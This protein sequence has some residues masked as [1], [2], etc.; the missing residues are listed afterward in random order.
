MTMKS[1]PLANTGSYGGKFA[2][3]TVGATVPA[4]PVLLGLNVG[5]PVLQDLN[6]I[7]MKRTLAFEGSASMMF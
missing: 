4:G 5:M 1:S 6:G 3:V 7:Q 2:D